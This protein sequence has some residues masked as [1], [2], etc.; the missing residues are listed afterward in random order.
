LRE[1]RSRV[2]QK[3]A[4]DSQGRLIFVVTW[5]KRVPSFSTTRILSGR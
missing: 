3:P 2:L 1:D 4:C 5:S